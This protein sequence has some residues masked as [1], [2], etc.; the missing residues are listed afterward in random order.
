MIDHALGKNLIIPAYKY[1][2]RKMLTSREMDNT[3]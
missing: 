2:V 3:I 1:I